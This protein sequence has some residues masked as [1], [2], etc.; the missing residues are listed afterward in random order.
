MKSFKSIVESAKQFIAEQ[1]ESWNV[2]KANAYGKY[3]YDKFE[4]AED[5]LNPEDEDIYQ[6]VND[7]LNDAEVDPD[8]YDSFGKAFEK[9]W[10]KDQESC[11]KVLE[12]LKQHSDSK[13]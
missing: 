12:V 2:T 10:Y 13:K 6:F 5:E 9:L 8:D 4:T 11:T 7:T 3:F 1:E